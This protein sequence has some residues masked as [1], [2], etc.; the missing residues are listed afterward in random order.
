MEG[1]RFSINGVKVTAF[2]IAGDLYVGIPDDLGEALR[3]LLNGKLF[4]PRDI[5]LLSD[6]SRPGT[7]KG[8]YTAPKAPA[9]APKKSDLSNETVAQH[10]IRKGYSRTEFA[11]LLNISRRSLG[12]WEEKGKKMSEV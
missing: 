6:Q 5:R 4:E 10:R 2:H 8:H 3:A 12:R 11:A 9:P 1:L 7:P